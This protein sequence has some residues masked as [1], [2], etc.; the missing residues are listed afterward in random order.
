[1]Q[2]VIGKIGR[3][4][5]VQ[6]DVGV[7]VRT[8]DPDRR[9]AAGTTIATDPPERGPLKVV[10]SRWHSGRLLVRFADSDDRTQAEALRGTILVIDIDDDERADDPDEFYDHHL[11]GLRA[12]TSA[13]EEVGAVTDVLHLPGQDVLAIKRTDGVEVLVPFVAELV[14]GV[15][16]DARTVTIEPRPGLLDP[17][18]AEVAAGN[19][20]EPAAAGNDAGNDSEPS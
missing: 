2:L 18:A 9:F 13:G 11:I 6:G 1:V 3:A 8:D 15:D 20:S 19:D 7:E 12:L 4:H 10:T 14:P 16:L 5:G 17:D